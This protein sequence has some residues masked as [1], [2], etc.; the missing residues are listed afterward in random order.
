MCPF[1]LEPLTNM[2]FKH[3]LQTWTRSFQTSCSFFISSSVVVLLFGNLISCRNMISSIAITLFLCVY[4]TCPHLYCFS[5]PIGT[6]SNSSNDDVQIGDAHDVSR[7]LQNE[8]DQ[9]SLAAT[10]SS[11]HQVRPRKWSESVFACMSVGFSVG[12]VWFGVFFFFFFLCVCG[13]CLFMFACLSVCFR[14]FWGLFACMFVSLFVC[15]FFSVLT[16]FYVSMCVRVLNLCLCACVL[17]YTCLHVCAPVYVCDVN[18]CSRE[19]WLW[20]CARVCASV[21]VCARVCVRERA[22]LYVSGGVYS[23]L[24]SQLACLS[25]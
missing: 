1:H 20:M 23:V 10:T 6:R 3:V 18:A 11:T 19:C 22:F 14:A 5:V 4:V 15:E 13:W 17:A 24:C 16:P 2:C 25:A 9:A 7:D 21:R 8:F 12:L